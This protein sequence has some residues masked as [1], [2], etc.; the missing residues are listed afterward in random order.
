M[1]RTAKTV[2]VLLGA[3]AASAVGYDGWRYAEYRETLA[4]Q[5]NH[6]IELDEQLES[7][8]ER[9][10]VKDAVVNDYLAHRTT[11]ANVV[12]QFRLL[13]GANANVAAVVRVYHPAADDRE[14]AARNAYNFIAATLPKDSPRRRHVL[15]QLRSEI[16]RQFS[17]PVAAAPPA[18]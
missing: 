1:R 6:A 2:A 11:F 3:L 16:D 4:A 15:S 13:N 8:G 12:E 17:R 14:V 10:A 9:L 18:G 7:A 5:A